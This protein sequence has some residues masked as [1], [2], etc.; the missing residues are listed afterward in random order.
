[1]TFLSNNFNKQ[2]ETKS[3]SIIG[4]MWYFYILYYKKKNFKFILKS[5]TWTFEMISYV[6]MLSFIHIFL[7]YSFQC[8]YLNYIIRSWFDIQII[9]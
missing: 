8:G 6:L 5:G 7:H 4:V 2:N 3:N 1:M 9:W